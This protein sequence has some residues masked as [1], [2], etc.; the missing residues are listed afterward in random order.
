MASFRYRHTLDELSYDIN[1][2]LNDTDEEY[3]SEYV[4]INVH[5]EHLN[6]NTRSQQ[7][8]IISVVGCYQ[9]TRGILTTSQ[10]QD[11][12]IQ[13]ASSGS[14]QES[15]NLNVTLTEET[16]LTT[17]TPQTQER[18][19]AIYCL[20]NIP[21]DDFLWSLSDHLQLG[22]VTLQTWFTQRHQQE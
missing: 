22:I 1:G 8:T 17:L 10:Q 5:D 21:D 20:E 6:Y 3:D 15:D 14:Y 13:M 12:T 4:T 16:R 18:L 11:Q 7:E 2:V 9:N 19:E